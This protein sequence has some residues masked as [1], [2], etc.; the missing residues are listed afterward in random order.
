MTT[1]KV[2]TPSGWVYIDN[3]NYDA[4][5]ILASSKGSNSG[6][7]S[8]DESGHVIFDQLPSSITGAVNY[9]GVFDPTEGAP[10]PAAAGYYYVSSG[11]GTISE[12]S[13]STGDWLVYTD[14]SSWNKIANSSASVTWNNVSNKPDVYT[15][16]THD[17]SSHSESYITTLGVTYEALVNNND[18]G[19]SANQ[20][21]SGVHTH[22]GYQP[23][24]GDLTSIAGLSGTAGLLRKTAANTYQLDTNNYL[25]ELSTVANTTN[26]D[27]QALPDFTDNELKYIRLNAGGDAFEFATVST[28][29][30]TWGSITGTL[31]NQTDL[32]AALDL[33]LESSDLADV[34]YSSVATTATLPASPTTGEIFEFIG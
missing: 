27:G 30:G 13:F 8:L 24:D 10:S 18:V 21:A 25:T 4:R 26:W 6:V 20:V 29:G 22:S 12:I 19:D 1:Y 17:N 16:D 33:K 3:Q 5:Y 14:G 11:V 7:A 32:Q 9:R 2:K 34:G 23:L 31:A 28:G 15:P